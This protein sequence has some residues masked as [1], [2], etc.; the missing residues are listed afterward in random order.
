M[1]EEEIKKK[2]IECLDEYFNHK[3]L[4]ESIKGVIILIKDDIRQWIWAKLKL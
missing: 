3:N 4:P 1:N 2:V